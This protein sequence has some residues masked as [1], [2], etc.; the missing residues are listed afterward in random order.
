MALETAFVGEIAINGNV[1]EVHSQFRVSLRWKV[2]NYIKELLTKTQKMPRFF[3]SIN[4]SLHSVQK[5]ENVFIHSHTILS[6][7]TV[8]IET[9]DIFLYKIHE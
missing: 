2:E 6:H 4:D 7:T 5:F 3:P 9:T 1:V 8:Y